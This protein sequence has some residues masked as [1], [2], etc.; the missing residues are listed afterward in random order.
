[1]S[2]ENRRSV[3]GS[4]RGTVRTCVLTLPAPHRRYLVLLHI[5]A[6]TPNVE[7]FATQTRASCLRLFKATVF[8]L[9][10]FIMYFMSGQCTEPLQTPP[11]V[12]TPLLTCGDSFQS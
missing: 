11:S 7:G 1:M 5:P 4:R 2:V 12:Q 6:S 3:R 10:Y 8:H 9:C